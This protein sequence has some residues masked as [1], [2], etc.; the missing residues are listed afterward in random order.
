MC[1]CD[2]CIWKDINAADG[3]T[4]AVGEPRRYG[5]EIGLRVEW[6]TSVRR[7]KNNKA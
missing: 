5:E 4:R 3:L 1:V 6:L 7:N 2:A